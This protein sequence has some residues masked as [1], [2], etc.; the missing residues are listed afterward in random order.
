M[1]AGAF[2]RFTSLPPCQGPLCC[3]HFAPEEPAAWI[4][5]RTHSRAR[6]G[7][8]AHLTPHPVPDWA[9]SPLG[10]PESL[11]P[12]SPQQENNQEHSLLKSRHER[13]VS[14]IPLPPPFRPRLNAVNEL[15]TL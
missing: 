3:P 2:I 15:M 14:A 1:H 6:M 13:V 9:V 12:A 7:T 10:I 11:E 5:P 4:R 8:Q